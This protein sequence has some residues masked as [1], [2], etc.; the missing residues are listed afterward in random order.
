MTIV[1]SHGRR[2]RRLVIKALT[3]SWLD[4]TAPPFRPQAWHSR[5]IRHENTA[6]LVRTVTIAMLS[7]KSDRVS[8]VTAKLNGSSHH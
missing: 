6:W 7:T 2:H 8:Q 4:W 3:E 1:C 5:I